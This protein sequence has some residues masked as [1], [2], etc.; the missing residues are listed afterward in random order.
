[1]SREQRRELQGVVQKLHRGSAKIAQEVVQKLH[2]GSAKIAPNNIIYNIV[3][4][5]VDNILSREQKIYRGY[6]VKRIR[7]MRS[8]A[9]GVCGQTHTGY[10]VKRITKI[11][12]L[13]I[14]LLK[15]HL[16]IIILSREQRKRS[17]QRNFFEF[18]DTFC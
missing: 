14:H 6:A 4:N 11:H 5:I 18:V 7:G 3:D 12:L 8:N 17:T 16:L 15:I 1:M 13:I 9:Y 10:A 2:E